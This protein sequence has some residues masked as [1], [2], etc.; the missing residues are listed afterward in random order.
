MLCFKKEL[1]AATACYRG[2]LFLQVSAQFCVE[3]SMCIAA[4]LQILWVKG[5]GNCIV[6]EIVSNVLQV[7]EEFPIK[8]LCKQWSAALLYYR[9]FSTSTDRFGTVPTSQSFSFRN[10]DRQ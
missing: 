1:D 5:K 8:L 2:C 4:A 10:Q 6:L 7:F 3:D 9:L